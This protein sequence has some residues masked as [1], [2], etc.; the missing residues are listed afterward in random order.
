MNKIAL[1][2]AGIGLCVLFVAFMVGFVVGMDVERG[3]RQ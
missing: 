2:Y 1:A 3:R